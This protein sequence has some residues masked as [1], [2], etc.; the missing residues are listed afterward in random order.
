MRIHKQQS[1]FTLMEVLI[2]IVVLSVG[3]LGIAGLQMQGTRHVHDAQLHTLAVIQAQDMADRMRANIAGTRDGEYNSR[4]DTPG[5]SPDCSSECTPTQLAD[6]DLFRWNTDNAA[7]LPSGAGQIACDDP[8][9]TALSNGSEAAIGSRCTITVRWDADRK[10][11]T[12]TGCDPD[13]EDDLRCMR[14]TLMP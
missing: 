14:I 10:D 5:S 12:G 2:S 7:I 13:D 11:A 4:T 9:G 6:Y 1:G 8:S 3:L